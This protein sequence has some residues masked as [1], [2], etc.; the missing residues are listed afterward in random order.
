LASWSTPYFG[1]TITPD[2]KVSPIEPLPIPPTSMTSA[3]S[4]ADQARAAKESEPELVALEEEAEEEEAVP[5]SLDPE[6]CDRTFDRQLAYLGLLDDA[7]PS[8]VMANGSP[9]LGCC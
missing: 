7:A 2:P 4:F 9:A 5:M 3:G 8:L 1:E 6:A